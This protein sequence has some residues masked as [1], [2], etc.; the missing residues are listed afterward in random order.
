MIWLDIKS[1]K[2]ELFPT[3]NVL[4]NPLWELQPPRKYYTPSQ[5]IYLR[6]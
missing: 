3:K 1:S 2:F 6:H 5:N 4:E